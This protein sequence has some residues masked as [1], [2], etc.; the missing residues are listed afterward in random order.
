MNNGI[1]YIKSPEKILVFSFYRLILILLILIFLKIFESKFIT[2]SD[3][4]YYNNG[5]LSINTDYLF[6]PFLITLTGYKTEKFLNLFK[7]S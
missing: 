6:F 2:Y 1:S 4:D 7:S 3:L 5:E